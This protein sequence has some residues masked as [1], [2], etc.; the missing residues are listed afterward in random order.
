MLTEEVEAFIEI[1][2]LIIG[3]ELLRVMREFSG[4]RRKRLDWTTL[5]RSCLKSVCPSARMEWH[6][7][8]CV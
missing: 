2:Y 3:Y 8:D 5:Q 6:I 1:L 7:A 4:K